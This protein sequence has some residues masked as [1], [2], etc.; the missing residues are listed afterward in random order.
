MVCW[1]E[2]AREGFLTKDG[3]RQIKSGLAGRV[4]RQELLH[5]YDRQTEYRQQLGQQAQSRMAELTAEM[6]RGYLPV[7]L[8][9]IVDAVAD[10]LCKDARVAECYKLWC[11]MRM[12]VLR[13][14]TKDPPHPGKLSEQAELKRIRNIIIEEAAA[15]NAPDASGYTA[16]I[17]SGSVVGDD[18]QAVF[19]EITDAPHPDTI[20]M[21]DPAP[22]AEHDNGTVS[23][24]YTESAD[25]AETY[26][27]Q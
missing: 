27:E 19:D 8:K 7:P 6:E 22:Q 14:Y 18:A 5:V 12:E 11:D 9:K 13:P 15:M 3:I 16:Q 25:G 10:E 17:V 24:S 20:P 1:S 26:S 23:E 21:N 2:D 4:F